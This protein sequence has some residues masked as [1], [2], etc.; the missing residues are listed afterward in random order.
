MLTQNYS[1]LQKKTG[2]GNYRLNMV[3]WLFL[4]FAVNVVVNLTIDLNNL[5]IFERQS[6]TLLW[7]RS[8]CHF[9]SCMEGT[10]LSRRC[11][12]NIK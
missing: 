9:S 6:P 11:S 7:N 4:S 10:R 2:S 1:S 8:D 3:T 5:Q 12:E